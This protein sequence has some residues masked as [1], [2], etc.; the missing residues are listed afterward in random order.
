LYNKPVQLT[1]GSSVIADDNYLRD[2]ILLPQ[3]QIAAGF[4]PS[5]PSF[6]G[7]LDDDD[8]VA[9]IA[10]IRSQAAPPT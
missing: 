2:S 3:K 4:A 10:F 9:L 7:Q 6:Q 1:D 8:L 5:M